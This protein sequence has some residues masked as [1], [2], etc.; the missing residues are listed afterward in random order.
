MVLRGLKTIFVNCSDKGSLG[1]WLCV[2]E[3]KLLLHTGKPGTKV[4]WHAYLFP[5]TFQTQV[6]HSFSFDD[7]HE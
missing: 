1:S 4:V 2:V 6:H 5:S 7:D 3:R